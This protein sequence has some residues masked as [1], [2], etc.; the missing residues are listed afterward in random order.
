M[1]LPYVSTISYDLIVISNSILLLA[2]IEI[3]LATA[4]VIFNDLE[5]S[6]LRNIDETSKLLLRNILIVM[7][8]LVGLFLSLILIG[9]HRASVI[10][11]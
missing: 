4:D 11:H 8:I 6:L 3:I 9:M 2:G 7:Y 1:I 5:V 10:T